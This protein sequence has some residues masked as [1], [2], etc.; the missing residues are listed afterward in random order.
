V[1]RHVLEMSPAARRTFD[2]GALYNLIAIDASRT[3][4]GLVPMLH[5][6]SW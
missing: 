1:I 6:S 4:D 2:S 3:G 5:W